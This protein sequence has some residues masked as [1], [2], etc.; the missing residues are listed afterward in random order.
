MPKRCIELPEYLD[1]W[2]EEFAR[3]T[4]RSPDDFIAEILHRYYDAWKIGRDSAYRLDEIVDKYLKTHVNARSKHVIRYFAQW[5]KNKGF[6]VGDINEQL[7]N[8]F[9]SDYLSIRS[10]RESTRHAYRRTLRRFMAFI[11]E[12]KA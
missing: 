12:A 8:K 9:L 5:I 1:K 3:D 2:L 10:V 7:I 4:A 11:K 6:E